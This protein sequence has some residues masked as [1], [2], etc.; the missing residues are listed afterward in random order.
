M[1]S[2]TSFLARRLPACARW[3]D[4]ANDST[5]SLLAGFSRRFPRTA[6]F[7]GIVRQRRR[8][9]FIVVHVV[10]HIVG[11]FLS[12]QALMQTRTEQGTIAWTLSLNTVPVIA[13]PAWLIFGDS[14][15]D[16]YISTRRLGAEQT[17]P[18]AET[19]LKNIRLADAPAPGSHPTMATL[20]KLASL[21]HT[22]GNHAELLIDGQATYT[23]MLE[24]IASA[25][26]YVLLQSYILRADGV[27]DSFKEQLIARAREGV[28]VHVLIDNFG[29]IDL[30]ASYLKDLRDAGV[31]A[32]KFMN[33]DGDL[34]RLQLNFRNH[35]KL[36]IVDGHAAFVGGHNLGDEYL[37]K[38]PAKNPWR[39]THV[40]LAGPVVKCAQISFAEDWYWA[41]G[42]VLGELDWSIDAED[43]KGQMEAV[44][45]PSGPSDRLE[46]CSLLFLTMINNAK[47]RL[48]IASPYFVPDDKMVAALQLAALR[49]VEV[50]ILIPERT[51]SL[52][53]HY[54]S[55]SFLDELISA[56]VE[57]HR[58]HH[59]FLH[60]KVV[61]ADDDLAA[62]GSANFDNRSF[63]LNFEITA[64]IKDGS[65]NAGVAEALRS[66]FENALPAAVSDYTEA[67]LHFRMRSRAARLL[68]PI[69]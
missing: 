12:L 64:V 22:S 68:A 54:S 1:P 39:D 8:P 42:E 56:G 19:L 61:L 16:G 2:S 69:Q 33:F 60:Q 38:N 41:T 27:G 59:G 57:V 17:R 23:S 28:Q 34:N 6:K 4:R 7:F 49:G 63:R 50:K 37:G 58:F 21:P 40:K 45:V 29:C 3:L 65:F 10:L 26:H 20:A 36:L 24:S 31:K 25:E 35:R 43:M 52:L 5:S 14:A 53:V 62:I 47:E 30:P 55:F 67:P 66:D 46:T 13:V 15:L 32:S 44:C 9:I 18:L 51:D 48:W 11:F